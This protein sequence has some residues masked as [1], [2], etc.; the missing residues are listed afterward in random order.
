MR[1]KKPFLLFVF[2]IGITC[3]LHA[4]DRFKMVNYGN[5]KGREFSLGRKVIFELKDK[6]R[7]MP[8]WPGLLNKEKGIYEMRM[9]NLNGQLIVFNDSI[10][11]DY[12]NIKWLFIKT[13]GRGVKLFLAYT[14]L[15]AAA[16][17][18]AVGPD[19]GVISLIFLTPISIVL[20]GSSNKEMFYSNSWYP[21]LMP[22]TEP[23]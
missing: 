19:Y 20:I 18:F 11:I 10:F 2:Y 5:K 12:S 7:V 13:S 16:P 23:E 3:L 1:L 17:I 14:V 6:N 8:N 21:S 22:T 15:G 9:T 4:Q